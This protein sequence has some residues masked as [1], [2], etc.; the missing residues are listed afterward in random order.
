M[1]LPD[2]LVAEAC[3]S[4]S[5][6]LWRLDDRYEALR[7]QARFSTRSFLGASTHL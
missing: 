6:E 1:P 4:Q 5:L 2:L 3:R 7:R